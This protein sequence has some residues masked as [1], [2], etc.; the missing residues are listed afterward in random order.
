MAGE[1]VQKEPKQG[2]SRHRRK[3]RIS[4]RIDMTPMVD[5]AFLLL[6]FYMVSTVFSMPQAMEINLPPADDNDTVKVVDLL[7]VRVDGDSRFWWHTG[8]PTPDNLPKLLPSAESNEYAVDDQALLNLLVDYNRSNPRMNTLVL[9]HPDAVYEDMVDMLDEIDRAERLIN[10]E[11]AVALGLPV[12]SLKGKDRF[13]YRYAL[14]EWE[15]R[16]SR[17]MQLAH[18]AT[19][20]GEEP[21][22]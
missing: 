15:D 18:R 17:Y 21:L 19:G 7:T 4:V 12:D 20:S 1:V 10:A 8:V 3:R 6:I 9:I 22:E 2:K 13:S 14:G 5:I 16:D 11:R